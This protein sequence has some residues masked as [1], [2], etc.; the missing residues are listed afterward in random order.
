MIT[1]VGKRAAETIIAEIGVDMSVFR[2]PPTW[3]PGRAAAPATMCTGGKR[4]SGRPTKGN[5]WLGEVLTECAW[6]AARSRDTYLSAQFWRLAGRIGKKKAA[7]AVG[8]SILV[9]AWH[10]S[11]MTVTT[12]TWV[13]TTSSAGHRPCPPAS[14]AQL[15]ARLPGHSNLA[16]EGDS[17]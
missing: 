14:R 9:I 3:P 11:P 2:P 1:G 16:H 10:L 12:R 5:R 7:M 13:A 17:L 4:R 8:H 15:Q 6:A